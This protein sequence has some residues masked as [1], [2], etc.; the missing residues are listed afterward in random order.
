MS[1]S[2]SVVTLNK[3]L[4]L[5]L[6]NLKSEWIGID[7]GS[8]LLRVIKFHTFTP[9]LTISAFGSV[10]FIQA[11]VTSVHVWKDSWECHGGSSFFPLTFWLNTVYVLPVMGRCISISVLLLN[12]ED[13]WHHNAAP[14]DA[15][16]QR[17]S[18]VDV[19]GETYVLFMKASNLLSL[20]LALSCC[21]LGK[22]LL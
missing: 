10:R 4:L 17:A 2:W 11:S 22:L 12:T 3:T 19:S 1:A 13:V 21:L 15:Q 14:E 16:Q 20:N 8:N 5:S 18:V 9:S 6:W 7:S